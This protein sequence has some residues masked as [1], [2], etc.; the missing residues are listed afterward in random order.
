M[1]KIIVNNPRLETLIRFYLDTYNQGGR[2]KLE[3]QERGILEVLAGSNITNDYAGTLTAAFAAKR[4]NL[5][6]GVLE[7]FLEQKPDFIPCLNIYKILMENRVLEKLKFKKSYLT[8]IRQKL[9]AGMIKESLDK[10]LPALAEA[11]DKY[12]DFLLPYEI[13]FARDGIDEISFVS[14]G[15]GKTVLM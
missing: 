8:V 2:D 9:I 6:H 3:D 7:K 14:E 15:F 12:L 4:N 11:S 5:V 10:N 1:S 13:N